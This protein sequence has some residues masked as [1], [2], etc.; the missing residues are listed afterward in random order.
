MARIWE[1]RGGG[2]FQLRED[3]IHMA[4]LWEGEEYQPASSSCSGGVMEVMLG[5]E[6]G[7]LEPWP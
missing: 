3:G 7:V 2:Q 5:I 6:D 4:M 1:S